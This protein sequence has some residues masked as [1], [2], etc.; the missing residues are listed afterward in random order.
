M[1]TAIGPYIIQYSSHHTHTHT[2]THFKQTIF[3]SRTITITVHMYYT[4]KNVCSSGLP[5]LTVSSTTHITYFI[6]MFSDHK[7]YTNSEKINS[8]V[9]PVTF[10]TLAMAH[11]QHTHLQCTMCT[12]YCIICIYS[13]PA[14][15][16]KCNVMYNTK[17]CMY[18]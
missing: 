5:R 13:V 8:L 6:F 3:L 9:S 17:S 18:M 15:T 2:H 1:G 14:S 11:A 12:W 16:R 4:N 10:N 7:L